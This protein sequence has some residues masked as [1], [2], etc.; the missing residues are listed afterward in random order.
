LFTSEALVD[1]PGKRF[2]ILEVLPY[3]A[4]KLPFKKANIATRNFPESVDQIR[5]RTGIK[6]GGNTNLFFVKI[7]DESYKVLVTEPV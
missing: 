1:F 3:K 5:K 4:K 6:V 7:L 2:R